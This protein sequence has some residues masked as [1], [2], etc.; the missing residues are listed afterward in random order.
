ML[1]ILLYHGYFDEKKKKFHLHLLILLSFN[2]IF[3]LHCLQQLY[4]K[5]LA[6]ILHHICFSFLSL[7]TVN[8]FQ[9]KHLIDI[10]ILIIIILLIL[11]GLQQFN[12]LFL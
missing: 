4:L 2:L 10:L 7:T 1:L 3:S 8:S 9:N 11:L 6:L 5:I 12:L